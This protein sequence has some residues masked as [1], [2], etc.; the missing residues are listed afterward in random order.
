[1]RTAGVALL[2]V[3]ALAAQAGVQRSFETAWP[4]RS[5]EQF[6]YLPSG[7]HT[8]ALTLGFSNLAADVLWVRAVSYFGGH[9][10]TE[11]DYPWLYRIL[12]QVT[13]LDPP[14]Q[15]PYLWGGMALALKPETGDESIAMLTR[16]MINYPGD[17]RY[18]FYI[19]FNAFYNQRDPERAAGF[20]RYAASLPG[21]P[22]YL[23][24]LAAS[25]LAETGRVDAA[26]RF[27]ETLAEGTRDELVREKIRRK[28]ED[29]RAN[30]I[31]ESLK[32]FLAG[33]RAPALPVTP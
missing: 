32:A 16:G 21:S 8:K 23:P 4:R 14:F 17:W 33:K 27:L 25:L 26:V 22:H 3:V 18:P 24:H 11:T 5:V 2:I 20:M 28:I 29:L 9:M 13:A 15:Y 7:R 19:G 1:V 6:I 12:V 30:R 10:L 31:P